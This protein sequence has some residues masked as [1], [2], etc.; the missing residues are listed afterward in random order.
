LY[1]GSGPIWI[2][3]FRLILSPSEGEVYPWPPALLLWSEVEA[4][5]GLRD[6]VEVAGQTRPGFR[7]PDHLP[8]A[9]DDEFE[10]PKMDGCSWGLDGVAIGHPELGEVVKNA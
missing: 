7:G 6:G 2:T 4:T 3:I 8:C 5:E 9:V 1:S 10:A